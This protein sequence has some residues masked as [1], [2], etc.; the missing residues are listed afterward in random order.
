M[1][2]FGHVI[3][4]KQALKLQSCPGA[5]ESRHDAPTAQ[6]ICVQS[7]PTHW[8]LQVE[9]DAQVTAQSGE[10]WH[11]T[12]QIDPGEQDSAQLSESMH[13]SVQVEPVPQPKVQSAEPSQA[14]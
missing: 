5:H 2:P 4:K 11:R 7:E 14:T 12:S 6:E 13:S 1:A 10:F 3:A 9:L 8:M